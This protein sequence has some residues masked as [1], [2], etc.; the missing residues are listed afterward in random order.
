MS[1]LWSPQRKFS[2]WRRLWVALAEAE[3]ELGLPISQEQIA[4]LKQHVDDIDFA[5]AERHERR[6]RHDVMA[7][8]HAYGDVCPDGPADHPPG[9]DKL[10]RDR[11]HRP[12]PAPRGAGNGP[13]PAG[14]RDRRPGPLRPA[15]SGPALPGLHALPAGPADDGG[16]AGLP[17]GLRLRAR[18]G[19]DRVPPGEPQGPRLEGHDRHAGQLPGPGRRRSREGPAAGRTDLPED[20]LCGKL[21][22][23][24]GRPIRGRST[25]RSWPCCPAFRKARTRWPPTCGSWPIARRSK[26][27]SRRSRSAR[28]RWPTSGTPC[29][30]SGSARW[31]AS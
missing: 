14:G 13:R 10:L 12:D 4:E 27:R 8:V 2:T 19:R 21:R 28:R 26:S 31:P 3:A 11:Q 18:P 17:V 6:L 1:E 16:Q 22:R 24:P 7:H 20:R 23:S 29:G 9:R 5:A 25:R 15:V 30:A